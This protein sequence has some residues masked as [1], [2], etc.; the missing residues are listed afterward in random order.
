V[1]S[2]DLH[3][4]R[5]RQNGILLLQQTGANR[6]V[7]ELFAFLHDVERE[8][9]GIDPEHG[10]RAADL[11]AELAGNLIDVDDHE[12]N[13]LTLAC[14]GHS[15]GRTESDVTVMTCWDA[16]RLDLGRVGIKPLANKLCTNT[17]K[18]PDIIE[19]CFLRSRGIGY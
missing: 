6:K 12:L 18:A 2:S 11:V 1:C 14:R 15:K 7:V 10:H 16:D 8:N 5:V 3:W 4:A 9:D 17:A 19:W 13:L